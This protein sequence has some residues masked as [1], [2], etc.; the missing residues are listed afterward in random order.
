M[1]LVDAIAPTVSSINRVG[2]TPTNAT[3]VDFTVA[4]SESVTGVGTSDF[5]L[6]ATGTASGTIASIAT[7]NAST[8][9]ITVNAISGDGTIRSTS[10]R[11][12]PESRTLPSTRSAA[13]SRPARRTRSTTPRRQ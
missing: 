6:T 13:D 3:T 12:A 8:Y 2:S 7:V 10:T 4:F 9:T 11:A 5:T 1:I